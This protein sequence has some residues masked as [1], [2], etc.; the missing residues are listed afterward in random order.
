[1]LPHCLGSHF[2]VCKLT[3]ELIC[4]SKGY[5]RFSL[6]ELNC[7]STGCSRGEFPEIR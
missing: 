7:K 1:M 5:L 4:N 6:H 2:A 3:V